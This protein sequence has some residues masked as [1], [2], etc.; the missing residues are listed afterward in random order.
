MPMR[1]CLLIMWLSEGAKLRSERANS[2][3]AFR[4]CLLITWLPVSLDL[5]SARLLISLAVVVWPLILSATSRN[6]RPHPPSLISHFLTPG[7]L[8]SVGFLAF[9]L[10][11]SGLLVYPS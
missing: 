1:A 5:T 7:V 9:C 3:K 8:G 11:L 4:A 6:F 2:C 10:T